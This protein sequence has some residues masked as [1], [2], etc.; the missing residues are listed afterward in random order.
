MDISSLVCEQFHFVHTHCQ[1]QLHCL[2]KYV[3]FL[4]Y[5]VC[6]HT[7]V[8]TAHLVTVQ[9]RMLMHTHSPIFT[10]GF[11]PRSLEYKDNLFL[12]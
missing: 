1:R 3:V 10:L 6:L 9:K 5:C 11:G 7:V 4:L 8:R 12:L 2:S